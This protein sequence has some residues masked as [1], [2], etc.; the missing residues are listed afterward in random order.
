MYVLN[1]FSVLCYK[2]VEVCLNY[3]NIFVYLKCNV[4]YPE[5]NFKMGNKV[6]VPTF[7][8]KILQDTYCQ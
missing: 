1:N 5:K 8:S 3:L 7:L 6:N 2:L 4:L